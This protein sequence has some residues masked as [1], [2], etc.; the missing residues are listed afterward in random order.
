MAEITKLSVGKALEK[1]RTND[2]Q[3]SKTA[4]LD[5]KSKA[6]DEELQRL[7][8]TIAEMGGIAETQ[9]AAIKPEIDKLIASLRK[10]DGVRDAT[11]MVESVL[12][13][14]YLPGSGP[15]TGLADHRPRSSLP[16]RDRVTR[17]WYGYPTPSTGS[18]EVP[19]G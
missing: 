11:Y 2:V 13:T 18:C 4:R 1:L 12:P 3:K 6:L 17:A 5:E 9:I 19:T 14:F 15:S 16:E 10:I 8:N 7:N